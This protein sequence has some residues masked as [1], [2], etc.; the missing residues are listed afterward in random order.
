M[1]T[2]KS[3]SLGPVKLGLLL[4]I[5]LLVLAACGTSAPAATPTVTPSQ[6]A[7]KTEATS[8]PEPTTVPEQAAE[9]VESESTPEREIALAPPLLWLGTAGGR[10]SR[11]D[12]LRLQSRRESGDLRDERRRQQPDP[13]HL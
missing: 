6:A 13:P 2:L 9:V 8:L 10:R 4:L 11:Q 12:R 7:V 5:S 1:S 3:I